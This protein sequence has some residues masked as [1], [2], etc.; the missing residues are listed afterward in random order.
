MFKQLNSLTAFSTALI[1]L[2]SCAPNYEDTHTQHSICPPFSGNFTIST[3]QLYP[4]NGDFDFN[5]CVLYTGYVFEFSL[6]SHRAYVYTLTS[7]KETCGTPQLGSTTL[8][9]TRSKS[10]SSKA[11]PTIQSSILEAYK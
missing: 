6:D 1:R 3:Y 9:P 10:S 5:A 4:E 11:S 7:A 2:A 8:T